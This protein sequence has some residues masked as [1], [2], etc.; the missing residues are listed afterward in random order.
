LGLQL[1][2][3]KLRFA[4]RPPRQWPAYKIHYRY[5]D[6]FYH[7]TVVNG[8]KGTAIRRLTIDGIDQPERI[9]PLINDSANHDV[10]IDLE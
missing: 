4:P 9:V 8:G 6:T 2:V 7:I 3:N 10:E 5:F 1:D